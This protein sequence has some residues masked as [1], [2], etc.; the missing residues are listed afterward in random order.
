MTTSLLI[1]CSINFQY[2]LYYSKQQEVQCVSL[3][4][5]ICLFVVPDS[6]NCASNY[7]LQVRRFRGTGGNISSNS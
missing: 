1:F 7:F 5:N 3:Y 2:I 6:Y 4:T